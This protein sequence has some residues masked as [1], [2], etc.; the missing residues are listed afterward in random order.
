MRAVF[1]SGVAGVVAGLA[2]CGERD[3][4]SG[5]RGVPI[6]QTY[7]FT[8]MRSWGFLAQ[9]GQAAGFDYRLR[10]DSLSC[11]DDASCVCTEDG[12]DK[13]S[14]S[15]SEKDACRGR[16]SVV[17]VD[18]EDVYAIRFR[19]NCIRDVCVTDEPVDTGGI[20]DTDAED[21]D[22]SDTDADGDDGGSGSVG[23]GLGE[24]SCGCRGLQGQEA[25]TWRLSSSLANGVRFHGHG[26]TTFDPP[27]T[28]AAARMLRGDTV[29]SE[30]GGITYTATFEEQELCPAEAYWP[31]ENNRA[32]C[33]RVKLD[34]SGPSPIAGT[35]WSTR[36]FLVPVFQT[37]AAG[38]TRWEMGGPGAF[39]EIGR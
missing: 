3:L 13:A 15:D 34:A 37:E 14:L 30:S 28:L 38:S 27:V 6:F 33:Y 24:D 2:G 7:E 9:Q 20:P 19:Y 36:R 35:Y 12:E 26:D 16:P 21:T 11:F 10:G 29:T 18:G 8:T 4:S 1:W 32:E 22:A 5:A 23:G 17:R 25:F 31:D 39:N